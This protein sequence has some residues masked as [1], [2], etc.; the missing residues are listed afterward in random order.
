MFIKGITT[1]EN[2]L[3]FEANDKKLTRK[4]ITMENNL[5]KT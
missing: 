5:E 3:M 2:T 4:N 1:Y